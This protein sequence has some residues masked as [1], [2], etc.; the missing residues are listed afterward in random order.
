MYWMVY[1]PIQHFRSLAAFATHLVKLELYKFL[2]EPVRRTLHS[3]LPSILHG[4]GEQGRT[5]SLMAAQCL[6]SL[7]IYAAFEQ[8]HD[9]RVPRPGDNHL[10]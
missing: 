3:F 4:R 2:L 7:N 9:K 8:E 1:T 10:P 6:N 5:P